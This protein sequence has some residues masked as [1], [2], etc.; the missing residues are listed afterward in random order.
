[1]LPEKLF[2]V[3]LGCKPPGRQ[4]EQHDVFFGIGTSLNDLL[5]QFDRFWPEAAGKLHIDSWRE[6][7]KVNGFAIR[8]IPR[9]NINTPSEN[10]LFFLN[11]GGY[12]PND[13]EEYHYKLLSVA[14]DKNFAIREAK[15]TA[16]YQHTGFTGANS[17]IDDKYGVDVDD[18]YQIE[19]ILS[20][21]L[22]TR[23]SLSIETAADSQPDDEWHIGYVK[24]S[25]LS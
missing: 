18:V 13:L 20:E 15:D 16:F 21:D 1:M 8:V 23:F 11:L 4:T 22:K 3:L 14:A 9:T 24:L 5:P 7:T 25:S 19:E 17:H 6:V 2:F 10:K 12:K